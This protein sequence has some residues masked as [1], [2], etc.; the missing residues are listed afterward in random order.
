MNS[1]NSAVSSVK[2][3]RLELFLIQCQLLVTTVNLL[4]RYIRR[5]KSQKMRLELLY[6]FS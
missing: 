6:I 1:Y 3:V 5:V 4:L 2:G